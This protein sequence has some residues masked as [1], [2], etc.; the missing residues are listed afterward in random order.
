MALAAQA[1]F[2]VPFLICSFVVA[3]TANAGFNVVLTA[4]L[5]LALIGGSVHV[6]KNSKAPIAIGFLLG[7]SAAMA[8]LNFMTA[9][10][11]GQLSGCIIMSRGQSLAGYSCTNPT[12]YGAVCAFAVLLFLTQT[13]FTAALFM[14]RSDF[15]T[16]PAGHDE[17]SSGGYSAPSANL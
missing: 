9:I 8:V 10:F 7:S 13:V 14:W 11:W 6:L 5:N 12:A 4:F 1:L 16:E 15:I 17:S 3:G 2:A